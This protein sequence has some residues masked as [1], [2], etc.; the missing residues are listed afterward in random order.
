MWLEQAFFSWVRRQYLSLNWLDAPH[1]L[2]R[3]LKPATSLAL[4]GPHSSNIKIE[5]IGSCVDLSISV[6][7]TWNAS[8]SA[9][10]YM[11]MQRVRS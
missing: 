1:I 8:N 3:D 7:T 2:Q 10:R 6:W 11:C 9:S 4:P 5:D